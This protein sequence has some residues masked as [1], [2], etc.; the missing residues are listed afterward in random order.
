MCSIVGASRRGFSLGAADFL[1]KP[2]DEER[3]LTALTRL[4]D[5]EDGDHR[6]GRRVLIIDD[7][8]DDRNLLRRT[9]QSAREAYQVMEAGNGLEAIDVIHKA[10]P[11]LVILDLVMPEMDGFAVVE[12]LKS[13]SDTRQIP[14]IIL[15]GNDL[16]ARESAKMTGQVAAV[17]RKGLF[18]EDEFFEDIA[19]A[20]QSLRK[21]TSAAEKEENL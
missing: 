20:L 5:H 8:P 6:E 18:D 9:L 17:I 4:G 21:T 7:S 11:D 14:I 13:N 2:V 12:S 16:A 10:K 19:R 1:I 15:T 3:L